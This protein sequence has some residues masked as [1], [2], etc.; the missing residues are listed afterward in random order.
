[1][2]REK[3]CTPEVIRD[4]PR[5]NE[6]YVSQGVLL[7]QHDW[8]D[9]WMNELDKMN[10]GKEGRPFLYPESLVRFAT[11]LKHA[12]RLPFRQLQGMLEALANFIDIKAPDY[13][14]LWHRICQSQVR[15]PR[16]DLNGSGWTL[17]IDSTGIKV[18]DRG[19]WMREKWH[20]HRGWIKVHMAVE[21]GSGAIVGLQVSTEG[22]RDAKFLPMLVEQAE[23]LLPGRIARVT[24]DGGYDS[25][26]NF[27][28]LAGKGIEPVI[29]MRKNASIKRHG[30]SSARP[31]AVRERNDLGEEQWKKKHGYGRR[32]KVETMF[33]AVKRTEGESV[34]SK[35]PDLALREAERMFVQY[36][37]SK[38]AMC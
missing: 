1:M 37:I 14:T 13:T 25:Y 18:S 17:A 10:E 33:S 2:P 15:L 6:A 12:L 16:P 29:K 24:A 38:E 11:T 36:S 9:G 19:E 35:R 32:W 20:V 22:A 3:G 23:S 26:D 28:F 34:R 21:V 31:K 8:V 27:D 5:L 7:L 4:W 30:H